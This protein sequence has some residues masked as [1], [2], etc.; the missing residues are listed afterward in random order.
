MRQG[1]H[2]SRGPASPRW[3]P[4]RAAAG[5]GPAPPGHLALAQG[6]RPGAAGQP[7]GE[8]ANACDFAAML[9]AAAFK[10]HQLLSGAAALLAA[11]A[12]VAVCPVLLVVGY[13]P[14]LRVLLLALQDVEHR[15]PYE[16]LLLC[17]PAHLPPPP[18]LPTSGQQSQQLAPAAAGAAAAGA[19]AGQAG[20]ATSAAAAAHSSL[21]QASEV[22]AAAAEAA[23]KQMVNPSAEAQACPSSGAAPGTGA[24]GFHLLQDRPLVIAAVPPAAHSRKPHLGPLLLPLLPPNAHCLEVRRAPCLVLRL[25]LLCWLVHRTPCHLAWLLLCVL[26]LAFAEGTHTP[27]HHRPISI[28]PVPCRCLL[29]SCTAGGPAGAMK[30]SSSRAPAALRQRSMHR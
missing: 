7:A 30:C 17:W 12:T 2:T 18:S 28:P 1:A 20:A 26:Y 16:S 11:A 27:M 5:L 14:L 29:G 24:S 22:T 8:C 13:P 15:R 19:T 23:V 10:R 9:L 3:P 6:H 25:W 21:A 4:C